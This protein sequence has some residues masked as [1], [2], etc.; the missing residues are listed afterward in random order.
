METAFCALLVFTIV[1]AAASIGAARERG[2]E[3]MKRIVSMVLLF[4]CLASCLSGCGPALDTG[5]RK[6]IG[7][8][9]KGD[10][11]AFWRAVLVGAQDAATD[12]G[13]YITFR[14]PDFEDPNDLRQQRAMVE[15]ALEN[16]VVGLV[17]STNGPGFDDLLEEAFNR[18]L[19]VVQFDSG[20]WPEDLKKLKKQKTYPVVSTVSSYNREAGAMA[21]EHM[22]A[23]VKKD[24]PLS[25]EPYVVGI[26]Q[27]DRS[28]AASDRTAGFIERFHELG[29][30]DPLTA[31]NYLLV[32][33]VQGGP[34]HFAYGRALENLYQK[35]ARAVFMTSEGVVNQVLDLMTATGTKYDQTVFCGFDAGKRQL[36]WMR[37]PGVPKLIGAVTQD[38]YQI[39]YRAVEQ[40]AKAM[41][42]R[43]VPAFIDIPCIWYDSSNLNEMVSQ[44][45]VEE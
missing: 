2:M 5:D 18:G 16:E 45:L 9:A 4:V 31:G 24:I 28:Q 21:A 30:A 40:C 17:L 44:S 22:F 3:S 10:D 23:A 41:E 39:G 29:E 43:G 13:Y 27:H 7:C 38:A 1:S 19:P 32:S 33:E 14:G 37:R 6:V 26:I 35:H 42:A 36:G 25:R 11:S 12:N 8:I 34:A 15:L 20:I